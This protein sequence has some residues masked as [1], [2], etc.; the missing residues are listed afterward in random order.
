MKKIINR[1]VYN[2]ETATKIAT[3]DNGLPDNNVHA[4]EELLYH[5]EKGAYFLQY[6]GGAATDYAKSYG[7]TSSDNSGIKALDDSEAY[8]WLE[9]HNFAAE[10]E[11]HFPDQIEEA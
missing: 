9:K 7:V 4:I 10:I 3:W 2:T 6:W 5:T 8:E 1:K 11:S